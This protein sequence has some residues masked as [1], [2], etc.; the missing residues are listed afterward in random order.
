[1]FKVGQ[2]W[3]T[4]EGTDVTI[5]HVAAA[6]VLRGHS[7]ELSAFCTG[8]EIC[9]YTHPIKGIISVHP[10][11]VQHVAR[12]SDEDLI[13]LIRDVPVG[14]GVLQSTPLTYPPSTPPPS[15]PCTH[16]FVETGLRKSWCKHCNV[17]AV[18]DSLHW[19]VV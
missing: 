10:N 9:S 11:G 12:T 5:T 14:F 7:P 6:P 13:V 17:N 8:G 4:R 1:M 18:W 2:V 15:T 16:S 19:K 3:K